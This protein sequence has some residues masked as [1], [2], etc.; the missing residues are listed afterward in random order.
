MHTPKIGFSLQKK[1]SLSV[2]ELLPLVRTSGFSAISPAWDA[3]PKYLG[4]VADLAAM[5]ELSI[6]SLHAPPSNAFRLWS[7][8]PAISEE[9]TLNILSA[10]DDCVRFHI[11][12]LVM[13]PWT[14][15]QYTFDPE[16]LYFSN[17]DRIVHYALEHDIQI[18]FENLE[19][20]PF[21]AALMHRYQ[22]LDSIGYC[23]DCGHEQCYSP[24]TDFLSLYGDRLIMTHLNDN[25]GLRDPNGNLASPDDLHYIPGDGIADWDRQVRRLKKAKPQHTLNFELKP[26]SFSTYEDDLIYVNMPL[27]QYIAQAGERALQIANKY[28]QVDG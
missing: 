19:G 8:D 1:Y 2:Q 14:G 22:A 24:K 25:R 6:Q 18:A 9:L 21:L 11:P 15:F 23:W 12:I 5:H 7:S 3:D 16:H 28:T 20:E 27:E 17:F 26:V 4:T 10:V 13:H